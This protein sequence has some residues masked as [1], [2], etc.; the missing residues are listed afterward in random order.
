[1][2][3]R[4]FSTLLFG[5]LGGS[6]AIAAQTPTCVPP[7]QWTPKEQQFVQQSRQVFTSQGYAFDDQQACEA[8]GALRARMAA[9][10]GSIG[11]LQMLANPANARAMQQAAPAVSATPAGAAAA[12]SPQ[13]ITEAAL[14]A[15]FAAWPRASRGVV[16][17]RMRD[18][19]TAN[20][21]HV[22]DPE[23]RIVSYAFDAPSADYT[24][25]VATS[26]L[27][28]TVK[29]G[30][31]IAGVTPIPIA[32]ATR[33][34]NGWQ[35][36]TVT[37]SRLSGQSLIPTSDGFVV[38]RGDVGFLYVAG[39]GISNITPPPGFSIANFQNGDIGS[40][41][42]I[43]LERIPQQNPAAAGLGGLLSS[44]K[45]LGAT[46]GMNQKAD[47]AL[48]RIRD[49]HLVPIDVPEDDKQ[50]LLMSD[51]RRQNAV[52]NVCAHAQSYDSLY[53]PDGSKNIGHYFWRIHWFRSDGHV[54]A[55][56]EEN[57][58]ATLAMTDLDS[59]RRVILFHRAM[60]ISDYSV[61]EDADGK[62]D[63][64]AQWMFTHHALH[65]VAALLD[66]PP[67]TSSS[68]SAAAA[69]APA[70]R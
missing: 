21:Q 29:R 22:V 11:T 40:T 51:C 37:G 23:G 67:V 26:P 24:D 31:A 32:S 63:V 52:V 69:S 64:D 70:S 66:R 9:L 54:I 38:V 1:M 12:P 35:V 16:F 10:M 62:V 6:A 20:G 36:T 33:D 8:V 60:G 43:L 25:V 58:V 3:R 46:L 17:Q 39:K 13:V 49:G 19:F 42:Y 34:G 15:R 28:I 45:S 56:S 41:G 68:A 61:G 30:R 14:A 65:D 59:G 18:G 55:I 2:R 44:I 7:S 50:V 4:V 53:Q 48:M 5:L 27:S 57:G 47:Y